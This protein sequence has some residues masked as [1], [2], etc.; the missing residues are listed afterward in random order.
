MFEDYSLEITA[1]TELFKT[2]FHC[3]VFL[4][5]SLFLTTHVSLYIYVNIKRSIGS[6]PLNYRFKPRTREPSSP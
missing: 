2:D 5:L 6:Q 4:S 3:Y 1:T